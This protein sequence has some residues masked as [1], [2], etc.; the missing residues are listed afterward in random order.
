LKTR[1]SLGKIINFIEVHTTL[2]VPSPVVFR[3][4]LAGVVITFCRIS[5][6]PQM[7]Q[8]NA[9]F[10]PS[11]IIPRIIL[12]SPFITEE[13]IIVFPLLPEGIALLVPAF[14]TIRAAL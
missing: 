6:T 13:G 3:L 4:D 12:Q 5:V 11:P 1:D 14:V 9:P 8:G 2:V 7:L 10:V